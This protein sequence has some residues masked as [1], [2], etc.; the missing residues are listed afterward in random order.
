MW[1]AQALLGA[2]GA[3]IGYPLGPATVPV[4]IPSSKIPSGLV[5][6]KKEPGVMFFFEPEEN[7]E[8]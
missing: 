4:S 6:A 5:R 1:G 3:E 2:V 8:C 7:M